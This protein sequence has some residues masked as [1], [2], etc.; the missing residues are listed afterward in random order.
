[1]DVFLLPVTVFLL[2]ISD[3]P[4]K[5][6]EIFHKSLPDFL[7]NPDR[8]GEYHISRKSCHFELA[9]GCLHWVKRDPETFQH[10][11]QRKLYD[12]LGFVPAPIIGKRAYASRYWAAHCAEA[13][14]PDGISAYLKT[15]D[16]FPW[17]YSKQSGIEELRIIIKW[18]KEVSKCSFND[19]IHDDHNLMF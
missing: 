17:F 8:S 19:N 14:P 11:R 16:S 1:L 7:F 3:R 10:T 15:F 12:L 9:L 2:G 4:T 13:E 6:I 5:A 18:L